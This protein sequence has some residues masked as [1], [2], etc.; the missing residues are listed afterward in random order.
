MQDSSDMNLQ[1]EIERLTEELRIA[2]SNDMLTGLYNINTYFK[3]V[4]NIFKRNPNKRYVIVCLDVEKFKYINDRYGFREGDRLLSYIGKKLQERSAKYGIVASRLSS[5]VFSFLDEEKNVNSEE[6]GAEVQSWIKNYSMDFEVRILV[7]IYH[8]ESKNIPVR[9]MCDRA[10]LAIATIKNNY[11]TNVAEYNKNVREN[12]FL[13]HELL[14]ETEKA[15]KD[16]E[17]KVYLQP[18]YDLRSNKI[19]GA[20]SLVRWEHPQRGIIPPTDFIPLFE[21][22][23]LIT[24]LDE[25]VWEETCRRIREWIDRG[26]VPI[27]VSINISRVDIYSPDLID[28]LIRCTNKYNIDRHFLEIE[29]TE[30]AFTND[31]NQ[32]IDVV[33]ELRRNGFT[34][35]MDDFGSGY[36]SLN[37]LKD[38][39]VDIIK[40]DTRFLEPGKNENNKGRE[41]L[42]SVI[43]MAKWI[44]LQIVA[45]GVETNEQKNFLIELG[46]YYAQGFYFSEAVSEEDF[47]KLISNPDNVTTEIYSDKIE[48][49][50]D[51]EEL[52][53]SDYMTTNL[54]N[55]ILGGVALYEFDGIEGLYL[56]KANQFYYDIT[57]NYQGPETKKN[58]VID[59]V[60]PEDKEKV[61][62]TFRAA[63][64][65]GIHGTSAQVRKMVHGKLTW[66]TV[67]A[68]FLSEN[69]NKSM[70]YVSISDSTESM[71]MQNELY[72]ARSNFET[73]L[74]LIE[75]VVI[76]FNFSNK[77]LTV[78]TK[79]RKGE[80]YYKGRVL[81]N[82]P[83]SLFESDIIHPNSV[84]ECK[85]L[86]E[87]VSK[88]EEPIS[89]VLDLKYTDEIYKR[90]NI[91][92][93]TI[94]EDGNPARMIAV[95]KSTG[96]IVK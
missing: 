26:F 15:F 2:K 90:C 63:K 17:F 89:C 35:L 64:T 79:S 59:R 40:I 53:H 34:V 45:E 50:I 21:K 77:K 12:M 44:G 71:S 18:K 42:E 39:S 30:S 41:I 27:P 60:L 31:E 96:E 70:Y 5:D 38:I 4:Q 29:I 82:V 22:N 61:L 11:L 43:R 6:L 32:I 7:G 19:M 33:D 9:L 75:A 25:Y 58:R 37:I 85:R 88:S 68:F 73:A 14:N 24:R 36:S 72:M 8:V 69:E 13:Q 67:R 74:E 10:N 16:N 20:E 66:L 65:A 51:I 56:V 95:V 78:Q 83:Q 81:E 3:S 62:K 49:T 93:K 54:L 48:N 76:E 28:K 1:D 52:F 87:H 23:R 86:G 57:G 55:N 91:T 84:E 92:A 94:C 47:E 46:C 80:R